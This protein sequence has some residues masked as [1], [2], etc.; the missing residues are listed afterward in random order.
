M[1][2]WFWGLSG[3]GKSTIARSV[4]SQL[5][6]KRPQT[7]FI[8]G[9][10][11]RAIFKHD[12][13]PAA[14]TME[15]RYQNACRIQA[16]C[17]WLDRQQIDV[18]CSILCVFPEFSQQNRAMFSEYYEVFVDVPI[19]TLTERDNKGLYQACLTGEM[20]NVVGIDI[21]YSPPEQPDLVI[22]NNFEEQALAVYT[23]QVLN[24]LD[25]NTNEL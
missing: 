18:V 16:M 2:I 19:P 5:K 21:P 14:Y 4:Y 3:A 11:I 6:K 8:D 13:T 22:H 1:V 7:V 25:K 17:Q 23:A 15:G 24:L 12:T 20:N 10:E 9:D